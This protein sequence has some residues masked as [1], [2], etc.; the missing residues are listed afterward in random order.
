[1]L[2]TAVSWFA[3][4]HS[5]LGD[6]ELACFLSSFDE[7]A[8]DQYEVHRVLIG[9]LQMCTVGQ[10]CFVHVGQFVVCITQ[11]W[12]IASRHGERRQFWKHLELFREPSFGRCERV[13]RCTHTSISMGRS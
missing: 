2:G 4:G 7:G 5:A 1:M 9:H 10:H 11:M 8:D 6:G 3:G 13:K 12:Q